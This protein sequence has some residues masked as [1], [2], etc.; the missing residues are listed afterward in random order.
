MKKVF[1]TITLISILALLVF[2]VFQVNAFTEETYL[3]QSYE[4]KLSQ[5][6]E[7]NESLEVNF[8]RFNSLANIEN[9]LQNQNFKKVNQGQVRYIQ[10]P[11]GSVAARK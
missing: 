3:I 1:L 7:E 8:S 11:G 6:S 4:K 2:Y 5:L 10:I 9:Y